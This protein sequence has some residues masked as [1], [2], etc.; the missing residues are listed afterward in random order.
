MLIALPLYPRRQLIL[1]FRESSAYLF[2]FFS[3]G[4]SF[5]FSFL[6]SLLFFYFIV[7]TL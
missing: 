5:F 1:K 4:F 2:H 7:V 6:P 3:L